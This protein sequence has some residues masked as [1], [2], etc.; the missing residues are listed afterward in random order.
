MSHTAKRTQMKPI[1]AYMEIEGV[2]SDVAVEI[3]HGIDHSGLTSTLV[4]T[5][6]IYCLKIKT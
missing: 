1:S 3:Q 5:I 2:N 4:D 6:R